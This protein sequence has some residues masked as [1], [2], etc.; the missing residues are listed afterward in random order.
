MRK[1]RVKTS[2]VCTH[3][4]ATPRSPGPSEFSDKNSLGITTM[5]GRRG[6]RA[7]SQTGGAASEVSH[8]EGE[9]RCPLPGTFER[10][11]KLIYYDK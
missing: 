9:T 8:S 10:A 11:G 4:P 2:N 3:A 1:T 7:G 6:Q 5:S